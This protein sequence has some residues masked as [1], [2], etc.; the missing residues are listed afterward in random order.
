MRC[1]PV[2]RAIEVG[3]AGN[4][5]WPGLG[6]KVARQADN[7]SADGNGELPPWCTWAVF[8]D[9]ANGP[10]PWFP[11]SDPT[12]QTAVLPPPA[13][14]AGT[15]GRADFKTEFWFS[16]RQVQK[17]PCLL[18][19]LAE[20]AKPKTFA[21]DVEQIAVLAGRGVGPLAGAGPFGESW[22]RTNIEWPGELWTSPTSQYPRPL[23][24]AIGE[25]MTAHR[26]GLAR[27][28]RV[29]GRKRRMASR[30]LPFTNPLDR[31][32][33]RAASPALRRRSAS[34]GTN[35]RSFHEMIS[36]E[37]IPHRCAVDRA[38]CR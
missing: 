21:D 5:R 4:H 2:I 27:E 37:E 13:I 9:A 7:S 36:A 25:I 22:S 10:Q 23:A 35:M 34:D 1:T 14:Q 6:R 18:G 31:D 16:A 33:D 29:P 12:S 38:S 26:L 3:D 15:A 28:P 11:R 24:L 17:S 19:D 32:S 20:V 8:P 30:G